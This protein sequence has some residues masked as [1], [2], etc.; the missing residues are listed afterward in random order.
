MISDYSFI[1]FKPWT[2]HVSLVSLSLFLLIRFLF[3]YI[4]NTKTQFSFAI[5]RGMLDIENENLECS[6]D[7]HESEID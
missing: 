4:F 1:S 6:Q 5:S 7:E 3:F 2:I